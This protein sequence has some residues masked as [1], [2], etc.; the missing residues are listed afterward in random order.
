[1]TRKTRWRDPLYRFG[2]W[3][4]AMYWRVRVRLEIAK[5]RAEQRGLGNDQ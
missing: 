4:H 1:M 2:E 5:L 3:L